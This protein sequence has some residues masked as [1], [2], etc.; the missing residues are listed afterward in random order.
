MAGKRMWA[1]LQE[2]RPKP[3]ERINILQ[4]VL[5]ALP[6]FLHVKH[7]GGYNTIAY[8]WEGGYK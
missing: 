6:F 3:T 2:G 5:W 1:T 7:T 4:R 8:L